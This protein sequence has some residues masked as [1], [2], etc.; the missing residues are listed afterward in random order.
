MKE[1]EFEKI[2]YYNVIDMCKEYV[3]MDQ[4]SDGI[5]LIHLINH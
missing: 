1:V 5:V 3:A 2:Q 4:G